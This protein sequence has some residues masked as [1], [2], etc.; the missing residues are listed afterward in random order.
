MK[1]PLPALFDA[2]AMALSGLCLAHC[3]ALPVLASL[4]PLLAGWSQA[5]WVHLLFAGLAL[6]LSGGAL[7]RARRQH[8][9]P[10]ALCSLALAGLSGLLLG[11]CGLPTLAWETPLTVVGS[12][13]LAGA[14][15]WNW[16]RHRCHPP[17]PIGP[18]RH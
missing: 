12:L 14:H 4:L 1:S 10:T 9:L 5:E 11:A 2:S 18:A 7:W 17:L 8:R 6:P 15:L 16:R 3:L 13:L